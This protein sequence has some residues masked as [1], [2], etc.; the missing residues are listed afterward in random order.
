M[1]EAKSAG[2]H[3]GAAVANGIV[4]LVR[5]PRPPSPD[6]RV[7]VES[8]TTSAAV[9]RG[10]GVASIGGKNCGWPST[11]HRAAEM[12]LACWLSSGSGLA[13]VKTPCPASGAVCSTLATELSIRISWMGGAP[14][15]SVVSTSHESARRQS[16]PPSPSPTASSTAAAA[17]WP[18]SSVALSRDASA[19]TSDC[20]PSA[21]TV[22]T[23]SVIPSSSSTERISD[24]A[25][26][27]PTPF[28]SCATRGDSAAAAASDW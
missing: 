6:G 16:T 14:C 19:A 11:T 23:S 2:C 7:F 3:S 12:P 25:T 4:G 20:C 5:T 27:L 24:C 17:A 22:S 1:N 21:S 28:G 13:V 15:P 26:S 8:R 10:S 18:W 9:S